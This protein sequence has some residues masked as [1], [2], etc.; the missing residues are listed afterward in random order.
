MS[1]AGRLWRRAPAWRFCVVTA[2]ATTALAVMFPPTVPHFAVTPPAT[3]AAP[4]PFTPSAHFTPQPPAPPAENGAVQVLHNPQSRT[5]IVPFAGRQVALPPG[6][7]KGLVLASAGGVPPVQETLWFRAPAGR[8]TGLLRTAAPSPASGAP[9]DLSKPQICYAPA[10]ILK[11]VTPEP[12]DSNPM[13]HEC[14]VL[15]DSDET[16]TAERDKVDPVLRR[17]LGRITDLGITVPDRVLTLLYYRSTETGWLSLTLML[18]ADSDTNATASR[19]I[20][21][22]IR[23]YAAVAHQGF[24]GK[25]AEGEPAAIARD[26][27]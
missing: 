24:D 6:D 20:E 16:S 15:V 9:G 13:V 5:G 25:L 11:E 17:A 22:W 18:P 8:L 14:W 12:A 1:A 4:A 27:L 7:W 3:P 19:R 2:L 23:R 26:P 10:A 21:T